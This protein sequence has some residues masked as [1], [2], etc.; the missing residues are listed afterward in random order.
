MSG[1]GR[2]IAVT[3]AWLIISGRA[4]A[5]T[6]E[7]KD[8]GKFF[9]ADAIKKANEIIREIYGKYDRDMLIETFATV[10]GDEAEREKVKKMD[11]EEKFNYFRKWAANRGEAAVVHGVNIVICKDPTYFKINVTRKGESALDQKAVRK[12]QE[13]ILNEFRD[14]RYDEGLLEGVKFVRDRF[15]AAK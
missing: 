5:V 10:P 1:L 9:S 2:F 12:L 13:I 6:P 14:K 15:A 4:V 3:V 11:R 7:I 8:E